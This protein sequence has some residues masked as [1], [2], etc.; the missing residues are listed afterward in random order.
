VKNLTLGTFLHN[1]KAIAHSVATYGTS[2]E[3]VYGIPKRTK[4]GVSLS[5]SNRK[6][7]LW[8]KGREK[9]GV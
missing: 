5:A 7:A 9:W 6:R 3:G 1:S 8:G 2:W 4:K